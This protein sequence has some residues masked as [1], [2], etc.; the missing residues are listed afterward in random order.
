[1][2]EKYNGK[3]VAVKELAVVGALG[4]KDIIEREAKLAWAMDHPNVV[5]ILGSCIEAN[6]PFLIMGMKAIE[7]TIT[8][9]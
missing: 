2:L 8:H 4:M 5:K 9:N 7:P 6:P 3:D 1:M